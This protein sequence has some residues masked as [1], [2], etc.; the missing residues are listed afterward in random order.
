MARNQ[1]NMLQ[2]IW[3]P[4][5]I[6]GKKGYQALQPRE[7]YEKRI[8]KIILDNPENIPVYVDETLLMNGMPLQ[9]V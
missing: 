4:A 6:T 3:L 9:V 8:V 1:T 7:K 2:L 5:S